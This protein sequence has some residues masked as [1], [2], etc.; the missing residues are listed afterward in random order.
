MWMDKKYRTQDKKVLFIT[1]CLPAIPTSAQRDCHRKNTRD[2]I[3]HYTRQLI[4]SPPVLKAYN[5]RMGGVHRHDRQVSQHSIPLTTKRRYIKVFYHLLDSAVVT[6]GKTAKQEKSEW[7][8]AAKERH[9]LTWI[10]ESVILS[11]CSDYTT[12]KRT[13]GSMLQTTTLQVGHSLK[14]ISK[15]QIQPIANIPEYQDKPK[16]GEML[17]L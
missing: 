14:A 3:K 16:N 5:Y 2:E 8:M 7:D 17:C 11:L 4:S 15:H 9:N 6:H 1:N 10:K 13:Y 12:R